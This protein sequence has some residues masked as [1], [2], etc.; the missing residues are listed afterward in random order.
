MKEPLLKGKVLKILDPYRVVVDIGRDKGIT[1]EMRF[2]IYELGEEIFDPDTG[3]LLD[4]LE[5]IKHQ[6]RVSQIQEKF[7]V[8]RSDET[9]RD[10][11]MS[12]LGWNTTEERYKTVPLSTAEKP[13][14]ASEKEYKIIKVGDFVRQSA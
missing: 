14:K 1:F 11:G 7:S 3:E 10:Y 9:E 13:A 12:L 5:I 8:M 4:R 6:L 2:I